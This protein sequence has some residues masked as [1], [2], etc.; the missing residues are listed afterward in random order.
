MNASRRKRTYGTKKRTVTSA[1]AAI[2]GTSAVV[3]TR[4]SPLADVTEAF[5]NVN[6]SD[7]DDYSNDNGSE[8]TGEIIASLDEN[9]D[10]GGK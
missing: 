5:S 6:I 7:N 3:G 1:A 4:R 10:L 8:G 2:F 9:E